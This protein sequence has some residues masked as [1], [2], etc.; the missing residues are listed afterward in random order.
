MYGRTAHSPSICKRKKVSCL[1]LFVRMYSFPNHNFI[2]T[3]VTEHYK[4]NRHRNQLV[5]EDF[6]TALGEQ[7]KELIYAEQKAA[8]RHE[9]VQQQ[10]DSDARIARDL[11]ERMAHEAQQTRQ[12]Q[13][14]Q[15]EALGRQLQNAMYMSGMPQRTVADD[16]ESF[17]LPHQ[18]RHQAAG[19]RNAVPLPPKNFPQRLTDAPTRPPRSPTTD[20]SPSS[21]SIGAKQSP[22]T[23]NYV[24]L[25]L[26]SG[27]G[28]SASTARGLE[29]HQSQRTQYT[30]IAV[31]QLGSPSSG[32]T[33]SPHHYD[34]LQLQSHTPEKP[35]AV[36][37][38]LGRDHNRNP[39][40]KAL[41]Y[42]QHLQQQSYD[43]EIRAI[44]EHDQYPFQADQPQPFQQH[45]R[46]PSAEIDADVQYNLASGHDNNVQKLS[47]QKYDLLVGNAG[48]GVDV[49]SL[50]SASAVSADAVDGNQ[51]GRQMRAGEANGNSEWE[52]R[53]GSPP[54]PSV[55]ETAP[56]NVG[57]E[58]MRQLQEFGV[59]A[60]EIVE[61]NR[62]ISQQERDE[63]S[64]VN[65]FT[66]FVSHNNCPDML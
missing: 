39:T 43:D 24:S 21:S 5:R 20:H 66:D 48:A 56:S 65:T 46:Q 59:P 25:D 44:A 63:V 16:D 54:R 37:I 49:S 38:E 31:G 1:L 13:A 3:P 36:A 28:M 11:A 6:P 60:D 8:R 52:Y 57:A 47:L 22:S 10:A 27:S 30:Q 4:G 50:T 17:L 12:L 14:A 35:F 53:R 18:S 26:P 29:A 64:F 23:L 62:M 42:A 40:R 32:G 61:I 33:R 15:D 58:R 41:A 55:K 51:M 19:S 34:H 45:Q 2:S 7:E 9:L